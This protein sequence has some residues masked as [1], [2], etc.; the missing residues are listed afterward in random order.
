VNL[1]AWIARTTGRELRYLQTGQ[2]QVYSLWLVGGML[3][4]LLILWAG[5]G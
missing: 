4:L 3:F 2:V 1:S 5:A